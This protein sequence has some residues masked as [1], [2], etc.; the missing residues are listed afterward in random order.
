MSN[1]FI[2]EFG[3]RDFEEDKYLVVSM[4]DNLVKVVDYKYNSIDEAKEVISLNPRWRKVEIISD[5]RYSQ[6]WNNK[7][8][9]EFTKRSYKENN[10]PFNKILGLLNKFIFRNGMEI[11]SIKQTDSIHD[12]LYNKLALDSLGIFEFIMDVEREF[13]ISLSDI[14]LARILDNKLSFDEAIYYLNLK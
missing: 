8:N 7:F 5:E 3:E 6:L 13:N 4:E 2:K 12:T 11:C 10:T 1:K 14:D 9:I